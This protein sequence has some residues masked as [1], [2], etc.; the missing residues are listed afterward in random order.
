MEIGPSRA[1]RFQKLLAKHIG[2]YVVIHF[3]RDGATSIMAGVLKRFD[4]E[5]G[6]FTMSIARQQ[7]SHQGQLLVL[8]ESETDFFPG[9]VFYVQVQL[10]TEEEAQQVLMSGTTASPIVTGGFGGGLQ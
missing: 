6:N 8:P 5:L 10:E 2:Q 7:K 3:A 4:E 1:E 9:D